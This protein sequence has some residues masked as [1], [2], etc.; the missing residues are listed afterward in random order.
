MNDC[1]DNRPNT[2]GKAMT[3][4]ST[5][6]LQRTWLVVLALVV[7]T[8]TWVSPAG[9]SE[10]DLIFTGRGW[11]HGR[12][13]GQYG[14]LGYAT[15]HGWSS[16]QILDHYYGGTSAG[17]A[18]IGGKVNP[19]GVR[20]DL[21]YMRGRSTT[22]GLSSGEII[23]K[24]PTGVELVRSPQNVVR[25]ETVG[26]ELRAQSGPGCDGPWTDLPLP[27]ANGELFI[28]GETA[29][30]GLSGSLHVCGPGY[31]V[32]YAGEIKA[33]HNGGSQRTVNVVNVEDYLRG[34][35]PN[36]MPAS[37]DSAAIES[38]AVAARSYVMA[39]DSRHL[40]YADTCDTILCQV[41]DG[42]MTERGG[43]RLATHPRTDAAIKATA[44]LVR[45]HQDGS[46]ARTEFSSSTGG[47]T[48]GATFPAVE[49]LGDSVDANPNHTWTKTIPI[50]TI[51]SRYKKGRLVSIDVVSRTGLGPGGGRVEKVKL[52]FE[53]GTTSV[54]GNSLRSTLG[55]K[56][57][58]FTPGIVG[59]LH[60]P[61]QADAFTGWAHEQYLGRSAT[62]GETERWR[63]DVARGKRTSLTSALAAQDEFSG[64]LLDD[65][66]ERAL[67]REA[68]SD[69]H[70]YWVGVLA[71]GYK[72]ESVGVLFYG[73]KE[74]FDRSGGTADSFVAKLYRDILGR[75]LDADGQAYWVG[76]IENSKA[77]LDD[78]AAGFYVSIES[79]RV[80]AN[81]L[82]EQVLGGP[83][84][85]ST[86]DALAERLLVVDDVQLAAEIG[87]GDEGF[88]QAQSQFD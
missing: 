25:I 56:S 19:A 72:L 6:R 61:A 54:S 51:E 55:L 87:G 83:P 77:G 64:K 88:R 62:V 43:P 7:G 60:T 45:L 18:P 79:R 75:E 21:R 8:L 1:I 42:L 35:V 39:G 47:H 40:P 16:A 46:V 26:N 10:G 52:T 74:Y 22:V 38:Q 32:W 24:A 23:L 58:W 53:D 85:P 15:D 31:R 71:S 76:K 66:Y 13:L 17:E 12:G 67:G 9:A 36:E 50:K 30:T 29:E 57:D 3:T 48:V 81:S 20:V 69:G 78:V 63:A 84:D 59:A 34:V 28:V 73:S 44:G 27:S 11:G 2:G 80:R 33:V 14:A 86:L 68:D 5:H 65:V 37:W 41:Y 82:Y 49:D 4:R 70:S